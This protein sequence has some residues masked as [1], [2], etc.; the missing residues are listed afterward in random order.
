MQCK[1]VSKDLPEAHHVVV[2]NTIMFHLKG[3]GYF[4]FLCSN[5]T[6]LLTEANTVDTEKMLQVVNIKYKLYTLLIAFIIYRI[7]VRGSLHLCYGH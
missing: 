4:M 1:V 2:I 5:M 6:R 3:M 7:I